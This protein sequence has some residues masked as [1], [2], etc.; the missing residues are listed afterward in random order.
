[1]IGPL[2]A[3]GIGGPTDLPIPLLYAVMGGTW[4]LTATFAVAVLA[5]RRPRYTDGPAPE[6]PARRPWLA[7]LGAVLTLW[8][9]VALYAGPEQDNPGVGTLY[10]LVWV[11]LVPLALAFG[12]V[13]RDLSPWRTLQ[14]LVGRATGRPDGLLAYPAWLGY[15]PAALGL[16]A[17]VLLELVWPGAGEA[18]DVRTW[19][20]GYAVVTVVG[21]LVLGPRWYDRADPFD[22]YSAL[23]ARLSPFVR[24][25]RFA[26][27]DPLRTLAQV[28]VAPGLV[29]V[30]AV[31]L[32][33]TAFDSFSATPGW[34]ARSHGTL[35]D[36]LVLTGFCAVVGLLFTAAAVATGG[37][38]LRERRALPGALAPSLVPIA[39]GYVAAH[40]LSYLVEKGQGVLLGMLD[41][42]GRGWQPLGDPGTAYV[43]SDRPGLLAT[44]K[45]AAVVTGHVLAVLAAHDRALALLP[46]RHRLTGQLAMMLLM[47]V[48]TFGGLYLLLSV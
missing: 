25:G 48:Y 10:V 24:D 19:V 11:G 14:A 41:P 43:L 32:G 46:E 23:V 29:A 27:H 42:L 18:T 9:L 16:L 2:A 3:H 17:F 28:P 4:A 47:V 1:V 34:Q 44:L 31:L 30:L 7:V 20:A 15:W 45:V 33:S 8:W 22:V 35:T 38:A 39:V 6:P 12:H 21:G 13:W 26:L 40:Y 5:W 36:A 37:V